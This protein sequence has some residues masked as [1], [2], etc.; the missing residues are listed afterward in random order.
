MYKNLEVVDGRIAFYPRVP[1][2]QDR[3]PYARLIPRE[4]VE[5]T[6]PIRDLL[7]L[8]ALHVRVHAES[9]GARLYPLRR[10]REMLWGW[11]ECPL[12]LHPFQPRT[13]RKEPSSAP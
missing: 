8:H 12:W 5:W 11:Q 10:L 9:T 6:V 13:M 2:S 1:Q 4:Q 3:V 7:P